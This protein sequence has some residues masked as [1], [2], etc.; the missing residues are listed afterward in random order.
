[1]KAFPDSGDKAPVCTHA[2]FRFA[3]ERFGADAF[4]GRLA[5][6]DEFRHVPAGPENRPGEHV[7]RLPARGKAHVEHC[8]RAVKERIRAARRLHPTANRCDS[9][10]D[11]R[12]GTCDTAHV[13]GT[14]QAT[15]EQKWKGK[16]EARRGV[17]SEQATIREGLPTGERRRSQ[18]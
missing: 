10:L 11:K 9:P 4:D 15:E 2:T 18:I 12:I 17:T 5:A 3:M 8:R 13:A 7:S 14:Q 1:L 16:G 6:A